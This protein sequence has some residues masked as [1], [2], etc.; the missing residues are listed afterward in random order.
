[1]ATGVQI[2]GDGLIKIDA[3]NK[4]QLNA[5]AVCQEYSVSLNISVQRP[6]C[7]PPVAPHEE[8]NVQCTNCPVRVNFVGG[9]GCVHSIQGT[10]NDADGICNG[11]LYPDQICYT[12]ELRLDLYT[13]HWKLLLSVFSHCCCGDPTFNGLIFDLGGDP[14]GTLNYTMQDDPRESVPCTDDPMRCSYTVSVTI[15]PV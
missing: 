11:E 10:S 8:G 1:M 3:E 13:Q 14:S 7:E 4:V 5:P 12:G 9:G 2:T 6:F 15:A